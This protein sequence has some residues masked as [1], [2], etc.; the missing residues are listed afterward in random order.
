MEN[1][2]EE[3]SGTRSIYM[4]GVT[5]PLIYALRLTL[6]RPMEVPD[7]IGLWQVVLR[8]GRRRGWLLSQPIV[9]DGVEKLCTSV[10][11]D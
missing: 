9:E 11:R 6:L 5:L 4:T 10:V 7:G 1:M 8:L 2:R 3:Y